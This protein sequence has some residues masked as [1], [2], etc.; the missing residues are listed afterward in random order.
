MQQPTTTD[1]AAV[2]RVLCYLKGTVTYGVFFLK[3]S[4]HLI[5]YSVSW[6]SKKQP[7]VAR[8]PTK[9]KYHSIAH[10]TRNIPDLMLLKNLHVFLSNRPELWWN[11][12]NIFRVFAYSKDCRKPGFDIIVFS[13]FSRMDC[14]VIFDVKYTKYFEEEWKPENPRK[15]KWGMLVRM[16]VRIRLIRVGSKKS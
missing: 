4:L 12:C 7:T 8:S 15:T 3:H 14:R 1:F 11:I 13:S 9:P 2:E 10:T 5:R 6:S 16:H